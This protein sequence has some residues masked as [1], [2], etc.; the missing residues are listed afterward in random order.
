MGSIILISLYGSNLYS[1]IVMSEENTSSKVVDKKRGVS[2]WQRPSKGGT[3]HKTP[4]L[5]RRKEEKEDAFF[6]RM[7]EVGYSSDDLKKG[8]WKPDSSEYHSGDEP[9]CPQCSGEWKGRRKQSKIS[10]KFKWLNLSITKIGTIVK[11]EEGIRFNIWTAAE[12][13]MIESLDPRNTR[14]SIKLPNG[15]PSKVTEAKQVVAGV[16]KDK[17]NSSNTVE[18]K[19]N[20]SASESKPVIKSGHKDASRSL[21][22][23]GQKPTYEDKDETHHEKDDKGRQA[24]S[25]KKRKSKDES[26]SEK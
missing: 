5:T 20:P 21:V 7:S 16:E 13:D 25:K 4:R 15:S 10:G 8:H 18:D 11:T 26:K 19:E 9:S 14:F 22:D 12:P 3:V 17:E 24:R 2:Y 1:V 6:S 23:K